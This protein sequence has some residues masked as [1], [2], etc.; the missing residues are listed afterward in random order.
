VLSDHHIHTALKSQILIFKGAC[1]AVTEVADFCIVHIPRY[2]DYY[3]TGVEVCMF[4]NNG[5][6]LN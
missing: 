5:V 4:Y 3:L 6:L 2:W 1:G